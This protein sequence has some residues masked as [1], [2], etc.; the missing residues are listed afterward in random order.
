M[1]RKTKIKRSEAGVALVMA[2]LALMVLSA[3]AAALVYSSNTESQV[4]FNYKSEQVAYFAAKAGLEEARDRMMLNLAGNYYFANMSPN[5]LPLAVPTSSTHQI[6]YILNEGGKAGSVAPWDSTNAYFDDELC[7]DGYSLGVSGTVPLPDVHCDPSL[8]PTGTGWYTTTPSQLPFNGS[9]GALSYKWV[10]VSLKLGGSVQSFGVNGTTGLTSPVC[11]NG[12]NELIYT[13]VPSG[14]AFTDCQNLLPPATPVYLVTSLGVSFTGARKMVQADV[15]MNPST[16]FPFGI[17]GTGTGCG[18]VQINGNGFTD[19]FDSSQGNYSSTKSNTG[20]D[21]GSNGNVIINGNNAT[22]GGNLGV[23]PQPGQTG[24][25]EGLCPGSNYT[26]TASGNTGFATGTPN[27]VSALAAPITFTPPPPP[28]PLPP[29]GSYTPP[30]C[31]SGGKKG[32]SSSGSCM[33][34][35]TYGDLSVNGQDVLYLSPGVYNLNTLSVTGQATIV[36]DPP[37]QVVLNM[38]GNCAGTCPSP[39][40]AVMNLAGGSL[41]NST[42]IANDFQINYAGNHPLTIEGG[43]STYLVVNAPNSPVSMAGDGDIYGAVLGYSVAVV[44]NGNFHYDKAVKLSTPSQGA[45]QM[46][47]FRHVAY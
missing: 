11:W 47:S 6:L 7:H 37:G 36:V 28:S 1:K 15:A 17:Y 42:G 5:P 13:A 32:K 4:N 40:P 44:G 39:L 41:T 3:I 22:I 23:L 30:S 24:V 38:G 34:P 26:T 9:A 8:T 16:N 21:V 14:N 29:V 43:A 19:S 12:T 18:D 25:T 35:G 20:G 33:V 2:L 31:S 27:G 45:L 46:L 10:R